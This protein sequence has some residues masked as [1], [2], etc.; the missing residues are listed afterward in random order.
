MKKTWNNKLLRKMF[1]DVIN[2]S[3][4]FFYMSIETDFWFQNRWSRPLLVIKEIK[5]FSPALASLSRLFNIQFSVMYVWPMSHLLT[6]RRPKDLHC[7]QPLGD[8]PDGVAS[9]LA[10]VMLS[11]FRYSQLLSAPVCIFQDFLFGIQN[12]IPKNLK[13]FFSGSCFS[14]FTLGTAGGA[15][16]TMLMDVQ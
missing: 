8:N 9:L 4:I 5:G 14:S 1:T 13:K 15:S 3:C 16:D 10:A 2:L 7:S 12:E 6:W 11:V